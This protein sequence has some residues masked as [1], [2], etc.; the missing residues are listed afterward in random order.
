MVRPGAVREGRG[1]TAASTAKEYLDSLAEC[2][3]GARDDGLDRVL[4]AN[5]L[6]ALV[7]PTGGPAWLIDPVNGDHSGASFSSPAAVAGYPH[8]TVPAGF[9]RGLPVGLSFVG[10]AWSEARLLALGHAYE[11]ITAQ[12]RPPRYAEANDAGRRGVALRAPARRSATSADEPAQDHVEAVDHLALV[13]AH[14]RALHR[15]DL[16]AV[17]RREAREVGRRSARSA[18]SAA[19]AGRRASPSSASTEKQNTPPG[20]RALRR[21]KT[22]VEVADVDEDVGGED[23]IPA[24]LRCRPGTRRCRPASSRS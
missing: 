21:A 10:A 8:L 11:K 13:L 16:E 7:A 3:K 22:G 1:D 15:R 20:H 6:D 17:L 2:R 23:E 19:G 12:R 5:R 9:V 18:G 24:R 4:K 14:R